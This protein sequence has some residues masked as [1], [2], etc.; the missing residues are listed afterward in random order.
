MEPCSRTDPSKVVSRMSPMGLRRGLHRSGG[1]R[2]DEEAED[3]RIGLPPAAEVVAR[4]PDLEPRRPAPVEAPSET[5]ERRERL[6]GG[7]FQ[8]R[9]PAARDA[10]GAYPDLP[11]IFI[12]RALRSQ[13]GLAQPQLA[14]VRVRA[15]RKDQVTKELREMLLVVVLAFIGL[16]QVVKVGWTW[17][18]FLVLATAIVVGIVGMRLRSRLREV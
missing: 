16:L 17:V 15:S 7:G 9:F 10:L 13:L 8:H 4:C 6:G 11:G 14:V 3:E 12:D 5:I 1:E 18:G 2:G